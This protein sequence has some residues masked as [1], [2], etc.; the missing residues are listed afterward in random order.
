MSAEDEYLAASTEFEVRVGMLPS[1]PA[2]LRREFRRLTRRGRARAL[3][4]A[5][6]RL[7]RLD[8]PDERPRTNTPDGVEFAG[9]TLRDDMDGLEL[10]PRP[11]RL[12]VDYGP[13]SMYSGE[14]M[15]I[16]LM[17]GND[18]P[19][20]LRWIADRLDRQYPGFVRHIEY[21]LPGR[22]WY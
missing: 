14:V 13:A 18:A 11:L 20:A 1:S 15:H 16:Y 10:L 3:A 8:E 12:L 21:D 4:S 2:L 9:V 22:S 6:A 7:R 17:C 19:R 5:V